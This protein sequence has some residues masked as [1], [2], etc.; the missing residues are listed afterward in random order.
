MKKITLTL[1][2][3]ILVMLAWSQG[4][5]EGGHRPERPSA[6]EMIKRATRELSLTD[7]QAQQWTEI[8]EK[9]ESDMKSQ[10]KTRATKEAMRKELTVNRELDNNQP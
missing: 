4:P 6:E 9:Y 7:E 10:S 5:K 2:L 8:H 3:M 1:S